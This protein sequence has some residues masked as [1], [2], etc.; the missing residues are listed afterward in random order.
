[1]LYIHLLFILILLLLLIQMLSVLVHS[2][3]PCNELT[4]TPTTV[5]AGY[6]FCESSKL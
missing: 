2:D 5:T 4:I 3:I 1:M 6:F